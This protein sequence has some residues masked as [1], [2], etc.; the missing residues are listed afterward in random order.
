MFYIY[1][2]R[3]PTDVIFGISHLPEVLMWL[4]VA[5][6]TI[7]AMLNA[8]TM[9]GVVV[10]VVQQQGSN[11]YHVSIVGHGVTEIAKLTVVTGHHWV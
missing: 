6:R 7:H 3:N 1:L 9:N 4:T 5:L 10:L 11:H 2:Q 8:A